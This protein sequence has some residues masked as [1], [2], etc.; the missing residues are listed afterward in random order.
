[1]E[2][3]LTSDRVR[4]I[5][6][7]ATLFVLF[8]AVWASDQW[9][10]FAVPALTAGFLVV[11]ATATLLYVTAKR[12]R[13]KIKSND[14]HQSVGEKPRIQETSHLDASD[15]PVARDTLES[16]PSDYM[17]VR[18]RLHHVTYQARPRASQA[19]TWPL[20]AL[21]EEFVAS[22]VLRP[23][24]RRE[25]AKRR[26][27]ETAK[28]QVVP[29]GEGAFTIVAGALVIEHFH[30]RTN[31]RVLDSSQVTVE[32]ELRGTKKQSRP[33]RISRSRLQLNCRIH[34]A[35]GLRQ[36]HNSAVLTARCE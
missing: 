8:L 20:V 35:S 33:I 36:L 18:N 7:N 3:L 23:K 24:L 26:V 16:R 19:S 12:V 4:I 14:V 32:G 30:G 27:L 22:H 34:R 29:Q 25:L 15:L 10:E 13:S 5:F 9:H 31:V 21:H 2:K 28:W 11:A 6:L 1:M 17:I